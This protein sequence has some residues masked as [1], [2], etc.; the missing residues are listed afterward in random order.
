M[1]ARL[2]RAG[3]SSPAGVHLPLASPAIAPTAH[4]LPFPGVRMVAVLSRASS[5]A[6]TSLAATTKRWPGPILSNAIRSIATAGSEKMA[7]WRPYF[8]VRR[9]SPA[10][11]EWASRPAYQSLDG[12]VGSPCAGARLRPPPERFESPPLLSLG[13]LPRSE[14]SSRPKLVSQAGFSPKISSGPLC[15]LGRAIRRCTTLAWRRSRRAFA[16][17]SL[18]SAATAPSG[19]HW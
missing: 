11:V 4:F 16:D 19:I 12:V 15:P 8:S 7:Y 17:V 9:R 6:Q 13:C 3:Q 10:E 1:C 14:G 2:P 18:L 5:R